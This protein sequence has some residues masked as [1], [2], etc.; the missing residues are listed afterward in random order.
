M[1]SSCSTTTISRRS[2]PRSTSTAPTP[3]EDD[4]S[5]AGLFDAPGTD[6]S[7]L[8]DLDPRKKS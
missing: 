6:L 8:P 7:T 2:R 3:S 1:R 5:A 4:A